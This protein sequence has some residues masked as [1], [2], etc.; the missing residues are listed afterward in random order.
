M[1]AQHAACIGAPVPTTS[2]AAGVCVT[3]GASFHGTVD[4]QIKKPSVASSDVPPRVGN[5]AFSRTCRAFPRL[6]RQTPRLPLSSG[7]QHL[8]SVTSSADHQRRMQAAG[9]AA[10][11]HAV[12]A[13]MAAQGASEAAAVTAS[14]H[15]LARGLSEAP[16]LP[17]AQAPTQPRVTPPQPPPPAYILF[18]VDGTWRQAKEMFTV[19]PCPTAWA[20]R[21]C[22]AR[23]RAPPRQH[24]A[25]A[26]A[27]GQEP[28]VA[29]MARLHTL[30][31]PWVMDRHAG[32][33]R[34]SGPSGWGNKQGQVAGFVTL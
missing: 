10:A 7:A 20:R 8:P 33:R 34:F 27:A 24:H 9:K 23:S 22:P 13:P 16:P 6:C 18:V 19:S 15:A 26:C 5:P 32:C 29:L 2:H 3:D 12:G 21:G 17:A 11:S 14:P 30:E 31:V 4:N 1:S 25:R 28:P